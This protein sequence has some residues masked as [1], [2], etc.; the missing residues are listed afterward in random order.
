[1]DEVPLGEVARFERELVDYF[2]TRH[3][4]LLGGIRESGALPDGDG[5]TEAITAMK[6]TFTTGDGE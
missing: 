6:E 3:S 1:M 5:M 2:R 4:D